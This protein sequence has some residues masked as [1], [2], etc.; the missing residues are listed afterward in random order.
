MEAPSRRREKAH[1]PQKL[2]RK[3]VEKKRRALMKSL[4]S[5][6]DSLLPPPR[7]CGQSDRLDDACS[8]IR[9]TRERLAKMEERREAMVNANA[10]PAALPHLEVR[11]LGSGVEVVLVSRRADQPVFF[12]ILRVMEEEGAEV[13]N[14]GFAV[15][16]GAAFHS[17]HSCSHGD[18]LRVAE[19][20][21]E[22][23][24]ELAGGA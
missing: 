9:E 22:V 2:E 7:G 1:P 21:K 8:Y 23:V 12:E 11:D 16:G 24:R 19:R 5:K 3:T 18:P 13:V 6:L 14:A 10:G 17:F 4:F 15:A 20:L